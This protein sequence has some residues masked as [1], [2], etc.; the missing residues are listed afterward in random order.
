MISLGMF[1][2]GVTH[3][4]SAVDT[5]QAPLVVCRKNTFGPGFTRA[6]AHIVGEAIAHSYLTMVEPAGSAARMD[7]SVQSPMAPA[8]DDEAPDAG[9]FVGAPVLELAAW[10]GVADVVASL[11]VAGEQPASN[12]SP[13][14]V[15][16]KRSAALLSVL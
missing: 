2:L 4:W 14:P 15:Q 1:L 11:E 13:V 8:E 16:V 9:A 10:V 7:T 5:F 3:T 12:V 6:A